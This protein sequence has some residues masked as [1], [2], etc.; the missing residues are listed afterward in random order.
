MTNTNGTFVAVKFRED[1]VRVLHE[2]SLMNG[3]PNPLDPNEYHSTVVYSRNQIEFPAPEIKLNT[4]HAYPIGFDVFESRSDGAS[5]YRKTGEITRCC[6]LKIESYF[7]TKRHQELR[8]Y[9][10]ATHDFPEY[11]PHVTL[12]YD[13]GDFDVTKLRDIE[14]ILPKLYIVAE[15]NEE[16]KDVGRKEAEEES[17]Q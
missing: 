6:V 1:T 5:G 11:H 17:K 14:V 8:R 4:W 16:L 10:N 7:M 15:F 12:S 3:I 9:F 2:Y 13:I